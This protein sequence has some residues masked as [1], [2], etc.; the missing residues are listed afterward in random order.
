[1]TRAIF[2]DRDGV[3]NEP[4][5]RGGRPFPPSNLEELRI[6]P[7]ASIAISDLKRAGFLL[8]V[9]TNQPDVARATQTREAVQSINM[10]IAATLPI[11]EFFVCWHDDADGCECRKPKPGL[12]LEAAVKYRIDLE[13]SFLIGDRWRDVDAGAAA[14][15][16]TIWIDRS[17]RERAPESQP[18]FRTESLNSAAHWIL[19]SMLSANT[20]TMGQRTT[21]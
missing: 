17:Y 15:C 4:V 8:L 5:V 14:G 11:D 19:S 9:I 6:Y 16:R 20:P 10:A 1:V 13:Q 3:L 2:L 12:I 21:A 18:N 7:E